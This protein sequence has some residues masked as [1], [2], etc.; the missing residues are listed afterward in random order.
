MRLRLEFS[1][2]HF[3]E[4]SQDGVL[5]IL[6]TAGVRIAVGDPL[7][8][9]EGAVF[10]LR[11]GPGGVVLG[12]GQEED[13][14]SP[15]VLF[16]RRIGVNRDEQIGGRL[17]GHIG[18]LLQGQRL[19][20][21]TR[22]D[23]LEL[24]VLADQLS[25][26]LTDTKDDILFPCAALA[27]G[28]VVTATMSRVDHNHVN[29]V[30]RTNYRRRVGGVEIEGCVRDRYLDA[31]RVIDNLVMPFLNIALQ[32]KRYLPSLADLMRLE[33]VHEPRVLARE[34]LRLIQFGV[35]D[36]DIYPVSFGEENVV[37]QRGRQVNLYQKAVS[38]AREGDV[39]DV[40]IFGLDAD[41]AGLLAVSDL[42]RGYPIE[43]RNEGHRRQIHLAIDQFDRERQVI[44]G[45][46]QLKVRRVNRKIEAAVF[47]GVGDTVTDQVP[48]EHPAENLNKLGKRYIRHRSFRGGVNV[49]GVAGYVNIDRACGAGPG[50]SY[51]CQNDDGCN[52]SDIFHLTQVLSSLC[53]SPV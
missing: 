11:H 21:V 47:P 3:V 25:Q 32:P 39:R 15:D 40:E 14:P 33:P 7:V 31:R 46:V 45:I 50:R 43:K 12:L 35:A 38:L 49:L 18:P 9:E 27:D 10:E 53:W 16:Q 42:L 41:T 37:G 2:N 1:H 8:F 22:H 28:P 20:T 5:A 6:D 52:D 34:Y 36:R 44:D 29:L 51:Q 13:V 17:V 4:N 23:N 24:L 48:V 26:L 30:V 19:V